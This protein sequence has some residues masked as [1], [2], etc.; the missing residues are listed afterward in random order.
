[1][2]TSAASSS[3]GN[4]KCGSY[5]NLVDGRVKQDRLPSQIILKEKEEHMKHTTHRRHISFALLALGLLLL[6][7][8]CAPAQSTPAPAGG[9][10]VQPAAQVPPPTAVPAGPK[11]GG[12]FVFSQ[13]TA[14]PPDLDPYLNVTFRVQQF[15]GYIYSRLLKFDSGPN[16]DPNSSTVVGDLAEKWEASSDGLT[17]TFFLRKNAKFHNKA[18]VNGRAVTADDVV[19]SF[20]RFREVSPNKTA[21]F[22]VKEVKA[23]DANTVVFT[24]SETFAPFETAIAQ[25]LLFIIPKEVVDADKD[26]RKNPIGSGPFMYDKYEK[27]IQMVYKRNPDYYIAGQPYIDEAVSLIIP[28]SATAMASLRAKQLDF[29]SLSAADTKSIRSTNPEIKI[30]TYPATTVAFIYWRVDEKP[31]NDVRLRQAVALSM[32][33]EEQIKVIYEGEGTYNNYVPAFQSSFHIDPRTA[34]N[35]PGAKF[36]KRDTVEAKRL[37]AEAGFP[38]GLKVPMIS[39]LNAYG[40]TFNQSVELIIKQLKEGGIDATLSPQDYAAYISSTFLGKFDAPNMVYGLQTP[41]QDPHDYL[42]NMFHPKGTRNHSHIDDPTL[43]AMIEK[44]M[45]M[46]DRAERKK[47]I[48]EIQRY[49]GEKQYYAMATTGLV[50]NATQ[51]WLQNAYYTNDYGNVPMLATRV[52]LDNKPK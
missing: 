34:D 51:P 32:D 9:A 25:P 41:Y 12:S 5:I 29:Y 1:M 48:A 21:L 30:F 49:L 17:Y 16:I 19:Y 47:Q 27:G 33:R 36:F 11:R 28:E 26:L 39:T 44:Q 13:W 24:L 6:V 15:A 37:L 22:M 8:G 40:N 10:T 45:R 50:Y 52:W 38:N 46:L 2:D 14:D 31:F 43:T 20:N 7:F 35:G 18:P 3:L 42:Y 4:L 23:K